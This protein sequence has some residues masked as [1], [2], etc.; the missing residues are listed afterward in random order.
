M[1]NKLFRIVFLPFLLALVLVM[2]AAVS[3]D[4]AR[5]RTY[6]GQFADV[7]ENAWFKSNVALAYELGII[8]GKSEDSFDPD[9]TLTIAETI[10]LAAV[11]NELLAKGS[12]GE[13][14]FSAEGAEHW[15]DPYVSY[16]V[17]RDIVTETYENYNAP[18]TR[19]MVA[20]LFSRAV[21]GAGVTPDEIN[22]LEFGDI[23]DVDPSAWYA[24]SVYRL[25]RWGVMVGNEWGLFN[26]DSSVR[27]SEI[28][29]VVTRVVDPSLRI[30]YHQPGQNPPA[31]VPAK[32]ETAATP[33]VLVLY[34]GENAGS[35]VA[36]LA[37]FAADVSVSSGKSSVLASYSLD[38]T[39]HVAL[40][41]D[42]I[43]FRLAKGSGYE[44][45]AAVRSQLEAAAVGA[46]GSAIRPASEVYTRINELFYL[47]VNGKRATIAGLWYADHDGYTTYALYLDEALDPAAVT[48]AQFVCGQPG[49]DTL[50]LCGLDDLS[51]L[52]ESAYGVQGDSVDAATLVNQEA[53]KSAVNDAKAG[54]A[55]ILFEYE[56]DRCAILYGAGL[57][58]SGAESYRLLFIF[59]DG[60]SQTVYEGRLK[61][62]RV[63]S[64]GNVLYY[65]VTAPDGKEIQH[66]VNFD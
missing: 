32:Q 37:G 21:R 11:S 50:K 56:A 41:R 19:A 5:V 36:G 14:T 57:Y 44:A 24:T 15:Y 35:S 4:Y 13:S 38:L 46:N 58:G 40:E 45:F 27:R 6:S 26:A 62:I 47:W 10:K 66:G 42:N 22:T 8:N 30:L 29:A 18:A 59:R 7:P 17:Q 20:V 65:T 16:A 33:G 9:G 54:A 63:N 12:I 43:S 60:T 31:E 52:V 53:F 34:E 51:K 48:R 64:N 49:T 3:A 2:T 39:G 61:S 1:K 25:A 23:P 28:S 55:E